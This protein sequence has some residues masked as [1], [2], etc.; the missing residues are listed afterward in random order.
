[1]PIFLV[2]YKYSKIIDLGEIEAKNRKEAKKLAEYRLVHQVLTLRAED[3][4][5]PYFQIKERKE[6]WPE[7]G[8]LKSI[9]QKLKKN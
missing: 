5:S 9:P 3:D 6:K 1:M 8:R 4:G 2:K 7:P